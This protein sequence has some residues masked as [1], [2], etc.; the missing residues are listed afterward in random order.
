VA[1]YISEKI[2]R[3]IGAEADATWLVDR[4]GQESTYCCI[5]AGCCAMLGWDCC[6]A[7]RQLARPADIPATWIEEAT[8]VRP[9]QGHLKPG[10]A[11]PYLGYGYPGLDRA[12]E[13]RILALLG[14]AW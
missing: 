7:R 11:T 12:G 6:G 4:A 10:V 9:E 8:R 1:E 14:V 13:R 2:W 5:N 3:P